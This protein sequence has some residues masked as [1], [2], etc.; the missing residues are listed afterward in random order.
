ME[1]THKKM[2]YF[3]ASKL[4][5]R[6]S[7]IALS[8]NSDVKVKV[9]RGACRGNFRK[10]GVDIKCTISTDNLLMHVLQ[11]NLNFDPNKVG[12]EMGVE[13]KYITKFDVNCQQEHDSWGFEKRATCS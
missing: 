2:V 6:S 8:I 3:Y 10:I 12:N 9:K 7:W 1:Q 11:L 13:Q 4:N 5:W